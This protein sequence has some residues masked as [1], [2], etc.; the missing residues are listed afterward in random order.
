MDNAKTLPIVS[1]DEIENIDSF[2]CVLGLNFP[3]CAT[4][5]QKAFLTLAHLMASARDYVLKGVDVPSPVLDLI[6]LL[7]NIICYYAEEQR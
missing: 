7:T 1:F 5:F 2:R 4:E 6:D 3:D